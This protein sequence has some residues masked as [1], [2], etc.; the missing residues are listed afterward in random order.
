[1]EYKTVT[2]EGRSTA[3]LDAA[4]NSAIAEGFKPHGNP[5]IACLLDT[6]LPGAAF[7]V[8]TLNQAM[9]RE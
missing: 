6:S 7:E 4:V 2:V 5:Y 3:K 1:M 9:V 8:P